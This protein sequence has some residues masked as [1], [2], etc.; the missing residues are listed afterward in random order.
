[1]FHIVIT[2][3]DIGLKI[4]LTE[5]RTFNVTEPACSV[6]ARALFAYRRSSLRRNAWHHR[7]YRPLHQAWRSCSRRAA[8]KSKF[9][10]PSGI[11]IHGQIG[12]GLNRMIPTLESPLLV[13]GLV[14]QTATYQ[15]GGLSNVRNFLN[16]IM[17]PYI[18]II[19]QVLSSDTTSRL[20][21]FLAR[22]PRL[23]ITK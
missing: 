20:Q 6:H 10:H 8:N 1:M 17:F 2:F 4:E 18:E 12:A 16:V 7:A 21:S 9:V 19:N 3:D 22:K 5:L 23:R 11:H 15:Q 14:V 13:V